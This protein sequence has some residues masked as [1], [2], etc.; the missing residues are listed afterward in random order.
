MRT[1]LAQ[2]SMERASNLEDA[3]SRLAARPKHWTPFAGGTD[4][5]VVL[6]TGRM[7]PRNFLD[8]TTVS[9]L[10]GIQVSG[11]HVSI[12][13]LTTYTEL[14][15]HSVITSEFP[16][17]AEAAR[18]T[19]AVAIQNRGTVGGN[20]ANASPAADLPPALLVYDA[21][22]EVASTRG[23]RRITYDQFHRGYKEM[24][25]AVDEL[26]LGVRVPRRRASWKQM[27]R[28]VGTRRAQAISKVCF[29]A[30]AHVEDGHLID[31]RISLGSVAPTV[32]RARAAEQVL[33]SSDLSANAIRRARAALENEITP[34]D[35][36]RSSAVYRRRVAGNLLEEFLG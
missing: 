25:L 33:T 19:G 15:E 35:D 29:A 1:W 18:Q 27:Y 13:A 21:E 4:L 14:L 17:I 26:I 28:K 2:F 5:M 32:I 36:I 30:A 6:E 34:I 22:L 10:H 31:V 9:E 7:P 16:L 23:R 12:G 11:E 20:I 3:L 24:D 8:I